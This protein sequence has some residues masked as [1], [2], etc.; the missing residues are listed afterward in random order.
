V[1]AQLADDRSVRT[2][3]GEVRAE[4]VAQHVRG[5]AVLGQVGSRSMTADDP[6]D[7]ARAERA[8]RAGARHRQQQVLRSRRWATLDP[9]DDRLKR[10]VV[11]RHH[12]CATALGVADGH[13][14][15]RR[16]LDRMTQ[17]RVR[18]AATF[19]DV[20]EH[21]RRGFGAPQPGRAE[22]VQQRE[23]ALA[24]RVRRSGIFSSRAN[25]SCDSAR[26]SPRATLAERTVRTSA[27]APT[28]A[29]RPRIAE[30]CLA[31]VTGVGSACSSASRY[32]RT[33]SGVRS[34]TVA[35]SPRKASSE[36]YTAAYV[37]R[38]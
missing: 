37:Q 23:V 3:V 25:S 2:G 16:A 30:R 6:R 20:G 22:Q 26:G 33:A 27:S 21:E 15:R 10:V 29:A 38:V 9:R 28:A 18:R 4:R 24:L 13:P 12:A 32:A 19:V 8:G 31:I 1:A 14:P 7:V 5:A 34:S 17:P 11:Q 35:C 36:R